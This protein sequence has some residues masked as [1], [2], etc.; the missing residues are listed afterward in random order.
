M[1]M[2]FIRVSIGTELGLSQKNICCSGKQLTP[3]SYA[4]NGNSFLFSFGK[5][6]ALGHLQ[7]VV[8]F[9][10][11]ESPSALAT[12]IVITRKILNQFIFLVLKFN[13]GKNMN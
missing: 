8:V 7:G 12:I 2:Q 4:Q 6:T 10:L 5:L 9:V 13:P 11:S 3:N 1:R